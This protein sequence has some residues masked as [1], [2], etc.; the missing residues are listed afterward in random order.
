MTHFGDCD[1][2]A[3]CPGCWKNLLPDRRIRLPTVDSF[4]ALQLKTYLLLTLSITPC[5]FG[6]RIVPLYPP[7]CRKRRLKGGV[8]SSL[9]VTLA[10][11]RF[12][13]PRFYPGQG[14]N[15]DRDFCSVRTPV[16]PLGPQHRVPEPVPSLETH[17]KTD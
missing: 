5:W 13:G 6:I 16:P 9:V 15:L 8:R 1:F 11:A 3:A 10:A 14:R 7:A 12:Q 4:K 2:S 17:L